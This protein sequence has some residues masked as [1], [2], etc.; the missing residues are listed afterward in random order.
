M[1]QQI[2]TPDAGAPGAS[3]EP[4]SV[5]R[6]L[7]AC[8]VAAGPLFIVAGLLQA[9]TRDGFDLGRHQLSLLSLGDLG[10]IQTTNFV[11]SGLL[12][13]G[14]AA[15]MRRV[16]RPDRGGTWGPLL[17]G[18]Y[19]VGLLAAGVFA[20]D[21]AFGFPP[22]TPEGAPDQLSWHGALHFALSTLGFLSLIVGCF[23]LA[24]GFAAKRKRGLATYSLATGV[25][26]LVATAAF[27][28]RQDQE[29]VNVLFFVVAVFALGW[30]SVIAGWLMA[31]LPGHQD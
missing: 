20:A 16:L 17:V 28:A 7:L 30:V 19:G 23:V 2:T 1:T 15:G 22:G 5:T 8:G 9:S 26:F 31:V 29:S 6:A 27:A 18:G 25:A 14:G 4:T 13:L 12:F 24:R 11:L 3:S 21:P 10:W